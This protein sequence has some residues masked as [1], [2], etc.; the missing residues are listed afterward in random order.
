MDSWEDADVE[1]LIAGVSASGIGGGSLQERIKRAMSNQRDRNMCLKLDS[2]FEKFLGNS[3]LQQL[4]FKGVSKKD[5]SLVSLVCE[6]FKLKSETS[7]EGNMEIAKTGESALPSDRFGQARPSA[8][9]SPAAGAPNEEAKVKIL[10]GGEVKRED[11]R[12]ARLRERLGGR[13]TSDEREAD[14]LSA[15]ARI[16][17]ETEGG[18]VKGG[19]GSNPMSRT[20]SRS[21]V[22][23]DEGSLS[24]AE[25]GERGEGAPA[26]GGGAGRGFAGRGGGGQGAYAPFT[27]NIEPAGGGGGAGGGG[28]GR[29]AGRGGGSGR[30]GGGGKQQM[31]AVMTNRGADMMDPDY[32][33]SRYGRSGGGGGG[34]GGGRGGMMQGGGGVDDSG[35]F[36]GPIM[37][38]MYGNG[39]VPNAGLG[40]GSGGTGGMGYGPHPGQ[41]YGMPHGQG[42]GPQAGQ[43]A[44][45]GGMGGY[46]GGMPYGMPMMGGGGMGMMNGSNMMMMG[47]MGG[48]M[49]MGAGGGMGG[50]GVGGDFGGYGMGG[51]PY[52]GV[53]YG[54]EGDG[55]GG[56]PA[57]AGMGYGDDG[58][59]GMMM[60][61]SGY[62]QE[63]NGGGSGDCGGVVDPPAFG[64][65]DEFPAL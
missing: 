2:Q 24:A 31:K 43:G 48:G 19:G 9:A 54:G 35:F 20:S 22:S 40:G 60:G 26:E 21:P 59:G 62:H 34:G 13:K 14:Y 36:P 58:G 57:F 45:G 4:R 42:Y 6:L 52:G 63:G 15:R 38:G 51:A 12:A 3:S 56:Q 61:G 1:T 64:H 37:G 30:G 65:D 33:R 44:F 29:G 17:N 49:P 5:Q 10:R 25:G 32:N 8:E 46:G 18:Q 47:G 27:A 50:A 39:G 7:P 28:A 23:G 11:D 16:F 41:A 55:G 53:G